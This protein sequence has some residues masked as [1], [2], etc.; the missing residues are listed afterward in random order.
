MSGPTE[1]QHA[2]CTGDSIQGGP[3]LGQPAEKR[4]KL[5]EGQWLGKLGA[6]DVT[7]S[8][9][10]EIDV[11]TLEPDPW[12]ESFASRK[13]AALRDYSRED[14]LVGLF[15]AWDRD[16]NGRLTFE[17]VLPHYMKCARHHN[18][19]EPE[20]RETFERLMSSQGKSLKD[21]ITPDLFRLW[22]WPLTDDQL[23]VHYVR[24]VQGWSRH[25]YKMN[26][27][28]TVVKEFKH[29]TL[30]EILDSPLHAL[31]GLTEVAEGALA[32]LGMHTVRD[33]GRWKCFLVARAICVLA[34]KEVADGD[35]QPD[36]GQTHDGSQPQEG[37]VHMNI[38]NLLKEEHAGATLKEVMHLPVTALSIFPE[39]GAAALR[40]INIRTI[41][42]LGTRRYFHW[43]NA[44]AELENYET[45]RLE[46][47]SR[48]ATSSSAEGD[49][50]P[51]MV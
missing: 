16:G 12:T 9:S 20:V 36:E 27:G 42:H 35:R 46:S 39:Q 32:P 19:F 51:A 8:M 10:P 49:N 4:L 44:M 47:Q 18:M 45:E 43:A 41:Q 2:D 5:E 24:H 22:L 48:H 50:H 21:G 3:D 23:A 34:A 25:P 29:K 7:V 11:T 15:E 14:M 38:R 6:P 17:E 1:S 28:H 30:K 40:R 13:A 31:W 37:P 26:I 33:V